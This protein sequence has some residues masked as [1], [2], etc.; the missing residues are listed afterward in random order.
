MTRSAEEMEQPAKR[1]EVDA[2]RTA[3]AAQGKQL[4]AIDVKIDQLLIGQVTAAHVDDKIANA[5]THL[6]N[7]INT[8]QNKYDPIVDNVKWLTRALILAVIGL[9]AN[10]ATQIWMK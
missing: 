2:V 9:V 5:K 1:W 3:M 7:K 10:V 6:E 4:E 8:L